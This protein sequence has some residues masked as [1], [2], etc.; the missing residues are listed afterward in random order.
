VQALNKVRER[1]NARGARTIRGLSRTFRALDSYDGNKKVDREEFAVGLREN[2]VDLNAQELGALF[3]Y[4]DKD[5]DGCINFDE[6]LVGIRGQLSARRQSMVD[7][8][9]LKFDKDGNGYIDANDLQGV[10]N[11]KEHPKFKSGEMSEG[12]IFADFLGNFNDRNHDG[13]IEKDEWNEYYAAV[14]ASI[15]ND[16]HFCMLMKIA[17]KLE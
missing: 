12:Q 3:V 17:W 15:D 10:Y 14:S 8:A 11:V 6:F 2:G 7:K 9:F 16:E 4:F 13:K 1:L 5:R